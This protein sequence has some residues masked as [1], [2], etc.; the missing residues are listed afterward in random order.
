[1]TSRRSFI[2]DAA[3]TMAGLVFCS[4]GLLDAAHAHTKPVVRR[5]GPVIKGKRVKTVDVHAHCFFQ[6]AIDLMGEDAKR[7]MPPV[8]GAQEHFIVIED[9][10]RA[11]DAQ[12]IDMEVLSINPF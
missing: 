4:C 5:G 11:M 10:L 12:G 9:R 1:M 6:D 3:G 2:K 8:K 7:V